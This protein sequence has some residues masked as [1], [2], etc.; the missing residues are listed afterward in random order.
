MTLRS[1]LSRVLGRGPAGHGS[2]E[3]LLQRASS[4]ALVPLAAWLAASLFALPAFD[5][6]TV[7]AW[8]ARGAHPVWLALFVVVSA[9]HSQLG[10]RV[11]IEDYVHAPPVKT[12]A[13]LVVSFGHVLLAVAGVAAIAKLVLGAAA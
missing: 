1:P 13:L 5:H 11:V 10:V 2:R 6:G 7:A 12:L 3:W 9:H 4:V 8:A